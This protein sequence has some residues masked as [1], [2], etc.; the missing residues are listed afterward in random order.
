MKSKIKEN[1]SLFE[2]IEFLR[3]KNNENVKIYKK[4]I[5]NNKIEM[6]NLMEN[7]IVNL[8]YSLKIIIIIKS[9]KNFA[10]SLNLNKN[11]FN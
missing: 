5:E 2:E 10:L 6:Q 8:F 1:E 11:N 7:Q 3:K 4:E 9:Q